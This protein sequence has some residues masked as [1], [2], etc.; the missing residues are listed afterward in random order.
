[1]RSPGFTMTLCDPFDTGRGWNAFRTRHHAWLTQVGT[2]RPL[3]CLPE[4]MITRLAHRSKRYSAILDA[5]SAEI[6]RALTS[7]CQSSCAVGFWH[8][9][10]ISY[11]YLARPAD[12]PEVGCLTELGWTDA[13]IHA[14]RLLVNRADTANLRLKGYAGSLL[15]EPAFL[16]EVRRL[17]DKWDTLPHNERPAFPLRRA[18]GIPEA[19]RAKRTSSAVMAFVRKLRSFLDRWGLLGMA[20]WDLPEP[21]G[22][23]IPSI[24]PPG[25]PA[26]PAHGL[27]IFLPLHYPLQD[28]DDLHRQIIREQERLVRELGLNPSLAGLSH[29]K[30]YSHIFEVIHLERTVVGRYGQAARPRDFIGQIEEALAV[31]LDVG[32]DHIKKL[33][34]AIA[35]CRKGQRDAVRWLR[36]R[37]R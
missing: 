3:Y 31:A 9:R 30:A 25:S 33:R 12:L 35:S 5:S 16:E 19:P 10:P 4:E 17:A 27:H 34:K 15:T 1:V 13:N 22:P 20:T 18:I 14:A 29:H 32:V 36:P 23:L 11:A 28:D 6:E 8:S 37:A 7:L 2:D 21:Q 24:L 26:L